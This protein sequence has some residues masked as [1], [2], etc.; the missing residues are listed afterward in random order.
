[1]SEKTYASRAAQ[2]VQINMKLNAY[3]K[4]H[5]DGTFSYKENRTDESVAAEVGC[6]TSSVARLRRELFGPFPTGAKAAFDPSFLI[7]RI[8]ILEVQMARVAREMTVTEAEAQKLLN[9]NKRP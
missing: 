7:R 4:E 6:K 8:E 3:L 2:I 1:M 9:P 5:D